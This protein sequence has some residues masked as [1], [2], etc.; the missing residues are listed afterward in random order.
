[1]Y[2]SAQLK[3]GGSQGSL[4]P[5]VH[6]VLIYRVLLYKNFS[7]FLFLNCWSFNKT[8]LNLSLLS[9]CENQLQ[10]ESQSYSR[11][12]SIGFPFIRTTFSFK[13]VIDYLKSLLQICLHLNVFPFCILTVIGQVLY[14]LLGRQ[15]WLS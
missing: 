8:K 9:I 12:H 1:M 3:T 4:E 11:T 7:T 13:L 15:K 6:G 5:F 2:M 10:A 14:S